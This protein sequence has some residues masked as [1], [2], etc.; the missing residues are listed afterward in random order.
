MRFAALLLPALFVSFATAAEPP[1]TAIA[2]TPD[3]ESV[4][5]A[6]QAGVVRRSWPDLDV[7][8]TIATKL[9]HVHD[10][11]FA[12]DGRSLALGGGTPAEEG[13]IEILDWPTATRSRAVTLH[14]DVVYALAWSSDGAM[15]ATASLD[16]TARL[17]DPATGEITRTI[18][19]HSRGLTSV[20][21][22][23]GDEL[24]V[25]AGID[26]SLR[27]WRTDSGEAV[28]SLTNHTRTVHDV[29]VRPVAEGLPMFASVGDDRTVRL[30]Q[31]TIGR[32]VR[33]V[34]LDTIPLAVAWTPDGDSIVVGCRDGSVRRIDPDT[35]REL[36]RRPAIRDWAR[37][38]A[39]HEKGTRAVVGGD[40]GA[41]EL[42]PIAQP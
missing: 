3:G 16:R 26:Q 34:R 9:E 33:F 4:V 14:D 28:R 38:I 27:V 13:G 40:D 20:R 5:V 31:P 36:E 23:P 35:V 29:A 41:V 1:V 32:M 2:F 42:V 39:V 15:L 37:A 11:S 21:F 12:P 10:V 17:V 6:S 19:G 8:A 22:L 7:E 24:L 18:R 25:T 30:W